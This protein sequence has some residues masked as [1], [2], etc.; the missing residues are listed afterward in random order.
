[1]HL[2]KYNDNIMENGIYAKFNTSKG[3]ILVELTHDKTPGTV[4]NFVGL[5]EGN[6]ENSARPQGKPYYDGL[7]FH[8]VISDFMIQG[9]CPLGTGTGDP[10]Y[11][12]DDEFRQDLRHDRPGVLSMANA[13]KGT[14]GSQFFIT[15]TPTPWLDDNH[16]VFGFVTEGQD[17]VDAIAQGDT[18]NS[19]EIIR[20]GEEA[21]KW[22]AIEAFRTFE[23]SREKRLAEEKRQAEER[24]KNLTEGFDKTESGLYYKILEKGSGAKAQK[25]KTVSV[26]YEGKLENGQVFDSSYKRNQ[27]IEFS[28]GVG[29]V[30][31]GWDEG[32]SLLNVGDKARFVI[33]P[34]LGYGTRGAGGVIPPNAV[35]VFDVELKNVK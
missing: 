31:S 33:P 21:Q 4:G 10:G 5:A 16:T 25:G 32:I 22:N 9:G 20:V 14:N 12:F 23:G 1:M 3:A 2:K 15:H 8:R 27:P 35:L 19:I 18:I 24:M 13:G 26:H 29:Q 30:I 11:K 34:H 6:L 28:L 7:T 17:V